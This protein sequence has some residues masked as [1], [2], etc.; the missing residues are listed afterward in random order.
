MMKFLTTNGVKLKFIIIFE[1]ELRAAVLRFQHKRLHVQLLDIRGI[2]ICG[3]AV[4]LNC[5]IYNISF[6]SNVYS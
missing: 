6:D 3:A 4:L 2:S 5:F 1:F